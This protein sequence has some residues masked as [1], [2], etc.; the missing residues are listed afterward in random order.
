MKDHVDFFDFFDFVAFVLIGGDDATV[1]A[2][3]RALDRMNTADH[4]RSS[5]SLH[6]NTH[7]ELGS[8]W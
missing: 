5:T 2:F 4:E 8:E 1:A 3:D 7:M 6:P